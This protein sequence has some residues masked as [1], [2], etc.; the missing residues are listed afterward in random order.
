MVKAIPTTIETH[1]SFL[2]FKDLTPMKLNV[3][4]KI[5]IPPIEVE[6]FKDPT[7]LEQGHSHDF[8]IGIDLIFNPYLFNPQPKSNELIGYVTLEFNSFD[9]I[10]SSRVQFEVIFPIH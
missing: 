10:Q 7:L 8:E 5:L 3:P 6:A 1:T 4:N 9:S 2:T